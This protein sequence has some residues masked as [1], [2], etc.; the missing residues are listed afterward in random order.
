MA[1]NKF[2]LY[3][4]TFRSR[5]D[6]VLWALKEFDYPHEVIKLD[7]LKGETKTAEFLS[8]NSSGKIPVLIHDGAVLTE[9]LAIMEYLNDISESIKLVP[10]EPKAAFK[11]RKVVH[12]GLTEIEPYLWIAIQT[13]R[14]K[15]LYS[16][17]EGTYESAISQV[18]ANIQPVLH[19]INAGQYIAGNEFT[20][21]DIYFYQLIEWAMQHKIECPHGVFE[22]MK[23]LKA[24]TS[25]PM[26]MLSK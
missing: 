23:M 14:L 16:W 8:L 13:S 3:A 12:Y 2:I 1:I 22:Y 21:A 11:Y 24:R 4:Y 26:E 17:P 10:T 20:L 9:S 6:R 25:F 15:T 7:P 18:K 19:R 5:A